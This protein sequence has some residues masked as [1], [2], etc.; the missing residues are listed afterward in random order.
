MPIGE[1]LKA[2]FHPTKGFSPRFGW[3]C[4]CYPYAPHLSEKD[5]IW[6]ECEIVHYLTYNRPESQGGIWILAKEIKI[7]RTLS[8][9]EIIKLRQ[10][11]L[12]HGTAVK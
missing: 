9:I 5:R 8:S 11:R 6:V 4:T 10:E 12:Q 7:I 2:E 1:W 3:H